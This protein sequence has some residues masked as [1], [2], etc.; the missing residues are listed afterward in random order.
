[1]QQLGDARR[2]FFLTLARARAHGVDLG[3]ALREGLISPQDYADTLAMLAARYA[4]Q[5]ALTWEVWNEPN[6]VEFW[7]TGPDAAAY[8]ALLRH[9]YAAV[10]AV[11][12]GATILAG[13]IA[14]NDR[15]FLEGMYAAGAA[16]HFDGLAIHPYTAGRAPDDE[17]EV[18]FSLRAQIVE[19]QAIMAAN[20][21]GYK[22]LY[23]TEF[24][25]SLDDVDEATRALYMHQAVTLLR[26]FPQVRV[27]CAYT[28]GQGDNP[29]YGLIAPDGQATATWY[30]YVAATR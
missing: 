19:M 5:H 12:P 22:P 30:A 29:A 20:G 24:G 1:M 23:L 14:F 4:N 2:H 3:E 28:I 6:L 13:S 17:Q 27:A 7:E 15:P 25:W 9:S 21:E 10:K 18:W 26:Q 16:G 11:A 8:T